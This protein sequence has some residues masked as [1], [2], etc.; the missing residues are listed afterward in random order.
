M[1]NL[2]CNAYRFSLACDKIE[3]IEGE[4]DRDIIVQTIDYINDNILSFCSS[5]TV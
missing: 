5:I 4:Y 3:L 1:S 2:G